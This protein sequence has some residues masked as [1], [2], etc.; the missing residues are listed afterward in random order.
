MIPRHLVLAVTSP[1][2]HSSV[3]TRRPR[4]APFV[5]I[6]MVALGSVGCQNMAPSPDGL[7]GAGARGDAAG[8]ALRVVVSIAPLRWAADG[9]AP[10]GSDI[11]TLIDPQVSPHGATLTPS[12][13]R[14]LAEADVVLMVGWNFEPAIERVLAMDNRPRTVVRLS[15][16]LEAEGIVPP[17]ALVAHT[18]GPI[19]ARSGLRGPSDVHDHDLVDPHAWL[20][21]KA[22][23][24]W[25]RALSALFEAAEA[26]RDALLEACSQVDAAYRDGLASIANRALI[27]HHDGFGWLAQRYGLEIATVIRPEG[28]G[29]TRPSDIQ[30]AV[31]AIQM[32]GLGAVFIEPQLGDRAAYRIRDLTG[33]EL[34]QVDPVGTE[35]WPGTM[36]LNLERLREGLARTGVTH[37]S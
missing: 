13:A 11:V 6:L 5:A 19:P 9:L 27:T 20:D 15:E 2:S 22:M 29:E 25:I 8:S 31:Q 24:A 33:V 16:V 23:C 28:I 4:L 18:H 36:L 35:D 32:F 14:A 34:I 7:A 3:H 17:P 30:R 26:P 1:A 12:R 21:P 10:A 37:T